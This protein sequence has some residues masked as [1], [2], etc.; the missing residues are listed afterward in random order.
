MVALR[1]PCTVGELVKLE[2][3]QRAATRLVVGLLGTGYEG[4]LQVSGLFPVAYRRMRGDLICLRKILRS[5]MDP[6][7]QHYKQRNAHTLSL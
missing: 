5:D 4:R 6:E 3:V 7:L 2:R 1:H